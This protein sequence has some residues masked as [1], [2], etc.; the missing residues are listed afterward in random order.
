MEEHCLNHFLLQAQFTQSTYVV[1]VFHSYFVSNLIPPNQFGCSVAMEIKKK[2]FN[3]GEN[4]YNS[5][6]AGSAIAAVYHWLG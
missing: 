1:F 4:M 2:V 6:A 3:L 5:T